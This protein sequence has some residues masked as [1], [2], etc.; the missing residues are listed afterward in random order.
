M[1]KV[2]ISVR[3]SCVEF[4]VCLKFTT[5]SEN[6]EVYLDGNILRVPPFCPPL[7]CQNYLLVLGVWAYNYYRIYRIDRIVY[8]EVL[9][10]P[11]FF[12]FINLFKF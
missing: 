7:A 6:L 5:K 9:R 10:Y 1:Q 3:E 12:S 2:E 8:L 4:F 11:V